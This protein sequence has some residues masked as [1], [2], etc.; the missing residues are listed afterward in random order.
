MNSPLWNL[1]IPCN[2]LIE[3]TA[4]TLVAK[5]SWISLFFTLGLLHFTMT[6]D[7]Q[8]SSVIIVRRLFWFLLLRREVS[9]TAV[10]F[11]YYNYVG[12]SS[13]RT[14]RWLSENGDR[15]YYSV[16][17]RLHDGSDVLLCNFTGYGSG[18]GEET[19]MEYADGLRKIV[20]VSLNA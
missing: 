18:P 5:S 6:A 19:S 10:Q 14:V 1:F 11:V 7:S 12:P 16:G 15:E 4:D 13:S 2:P 8:R 20:G 9:F 3:S 17:L